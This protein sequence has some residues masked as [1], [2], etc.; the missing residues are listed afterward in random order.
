MFSV[1]CQESAGCRGLWPPLLRLLCGPAQDMPRMA[2]HLNSGA[3]FLPEASPHPPT[4]SYFFP[5]L[6]YS[7]W[8]SSLYVITFCPLSFSGGWSPAGE[9]L[10]FPSPL[11]RSGH[12][13]G[14]R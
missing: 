3:A 5:G 2:T 12:S 10:P 14:V 1:M 6:L 13:V 7:L 8:Q 11:A 4:W 9:G